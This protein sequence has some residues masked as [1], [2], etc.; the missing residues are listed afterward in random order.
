MRFIFINILIFLLILT[1]GCPEKPWDPRNFYP[2]GSYFG[3]YILISSKHHLKD[4]QWIDFIPLTSS[5]GNQLSPANIQIINNHVVKE[6]IKIDKGKTSGKTLNLTG[7]I[8]HFE[9]QPLKVVV[10]VDLLDASSGKQVMTANVL[11]LEGFNG[12]YSAVGQ[13]I[14]YGIKKL[15]NDNQYLPAGAAKEKRAQLWKIGLVFG[16]ATPEIKIETPGSGPWIGAVSGAVEG[17]KTGSAS[18]VQ[19]LLNANLTTSSGNEDFLFLELAI[20]S[21]GTAVGTIAGGVDGAFTAESA[22]T[23]ETA[24][25]EFQQA[26]RQLRIREDLEHHLLQEV[27]RKTPY[28]IVYLKTSMDWSVNNDKAFETMDYAEIDALLDIKRHSLGLRGNWSTNN[29]LYLFEEAEVRFLRAED[30]SVVDEE[31]FSFHSEKHTFQEWADNKAELF[32][33]SLDLGHK[34]LAEKIVE[35]LV[36]KSHIFF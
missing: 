10:R 13:G 33:K 21:L 17:A 11:G 4:Y 7:Q 14:A 19:A 16:Q 9:K 31:T 6:L 5:I 22:R 15:L 12:G 2:P 8:I 30:Q 24:K 29:L 34:E 20:I 1:S 18:A 35:N 27:A 23:I 25:E 32:R 36:E 28:E 26:V 3:E